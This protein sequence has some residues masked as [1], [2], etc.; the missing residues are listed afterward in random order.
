MLVHL[1]LRGQQHLQLLQPPLLGLDLVPQV[2]DLGGDLG[3]DVLEVGLQFP[4]LALACLGGYA[5]GLL[6]DLVERL[7]NLLNVS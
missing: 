1:P 3:D 7:D 4:G 2:V 5:I 6:E